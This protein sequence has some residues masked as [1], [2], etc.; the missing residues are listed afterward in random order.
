[1][2]YSELAVALLDNMQ[3]LSKAAPQKCIEEA[4][5]GEAFVLQCIAR[6]GEEV[7]P[8]EI[9]EETHASTARIA[10]TLNSMEKKGW[11]TRRIDPRDRRKILVK[12]TPEGKSIADRRYATIVAMVTQALTLLGEEDAREYVRITGKLADTMATYTE[13]ILS[14]LADFG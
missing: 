6:H 5:K 1:M 13:A 3:S 12:L 9:G 4:L 10:Q 11:L 14:G 7:L 2:D 8:G